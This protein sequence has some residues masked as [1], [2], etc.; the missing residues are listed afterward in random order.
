MSL[1]VPT[2]KATA[3]IP[4][5]NLSVDVTIRK[6][7]DATLPASHLMEINFQVSDSFIGGTI[8]SLPGVLLKNE[9]PGTGHAFS[10]GFRP[11]GG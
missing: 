8:A 5:R 7:A 4:A 2:I 6:N 11:R 9:E 3:S 10:R 1:G